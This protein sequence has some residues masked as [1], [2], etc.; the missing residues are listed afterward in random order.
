MDTGTYIGVGR[1]DGKKAGEYSPILYRSAVWKVEAWKT[2]WLSETPDKPGKVHSYVPLLT[3]HDGRLL[4]C[5]RAGTQR[6]SA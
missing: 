5:N 4:I 6:P 3:L 2:V 1:D